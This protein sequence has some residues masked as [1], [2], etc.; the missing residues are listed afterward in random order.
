MTFPQRKAT[1]LQSLDFFPVVK[2]SDWQGMIRL[3]SRK[4]STSWSSGQGTGLET[5]WAGGPKFHES[6][7]QHGNRVSNPRPRSV[8][9]QLYFFVCHFKTQL[10]FRGMAENWLSA[11]KSMTDEKHSILYISFPVAN[12]SRK[13]PVGRNC[14]CFAYFPSRFAYVS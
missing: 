2:I 9:S 5:R 4:M 7:S 12:C 11:A 6:R 1:S 13:L 3:T 14:G 8:N 10:R